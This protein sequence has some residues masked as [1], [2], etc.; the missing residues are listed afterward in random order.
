MLSFMEKKIQKTKSNRKTEYWKTS[1]AF[2]YFPWWNLNQWNF[3][4]WKPCCD[5]LPSLRV[6]LIFRINEFSELTMGS[7]GNWKNMFREQ[8]NLCFS[9][10]VKT[11]V[12][13]FH[14]VTAQNTGH[15]AF[16]NVRCEM[17]H[18][19]YWN[20]KHLH[21]QVWKLRNVSTLPNEK[22]KQPL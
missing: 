13:G 18:P 16:I 6:Q 2:R 1:N 17:F 9:L 15:F 3:Y 19:C 7:S 22:V 12:V 10:E 8:N 4:N 5:S 20:S 14:F 21:L 11:V